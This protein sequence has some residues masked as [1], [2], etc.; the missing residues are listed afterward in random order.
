MRIKGWISGLVLATLS[1][2]AGMNNTESGALGGGI[3]GAAAGTIIGGAT[4]H[5]G[6]GALIGAAAGG[7]TG[8]AIG[9]SEDRFERRQVAAAQ[10]YARAHP[11]MST[12]DVIQLA[13]SHT[14]PDQIIRQIETTGSW[15][16]LSTEDLIEL[17][18]Q[19]VPDQVISVMQARRSP[20]PVYMRPYRD[21]VV[22]EPAPVS[23]G[24][25]FQ[26]RPATRLVMY[27][28]LFH[29]LE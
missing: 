1:G 13:Q 27:R 24:V 26:Q 10:A 3:L 5:A 22:V 19:G 11:P 2:C 28:L 17:R 29:D 25:G 15:F 18:Q 20:P 7:L 14:P 21:V 12:R 4:G 8:A 16:I 9:N 23:F 6:A